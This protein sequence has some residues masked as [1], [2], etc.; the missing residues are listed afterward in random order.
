[1]VKH[2]DAKSKYRVIK[3]TIAG[4]FALLLIM[5]VTLYI[6]ENNLKNVTLNFNGHVY[7]ARTLETTIAGFMKDN[8]IPFNDNVD[9][10]SV[11]VND[12][13]EKEANTIAIKTAVPVTVKWDGNEKEVMTYY[14]TVGQLLDEMK[15]TVYEDDKLLNCSLDTSLSANMTIEIVRVTKGIKIEKTL[16]QNYIELIENQNMALNETHVLDDGQLGEKTYIYEITYENGVEVNRQ[17]SLEEVTREPVN[18]K[19]EIG[20]IPSKTDPN[21]GKTFMYLRYET[22]VATAYTLDP[23]ECGGKAPGDPGYGITA[24]GM[25]ADTGVIA[26]DKSVIP[27]GTKVYIET[28]SGAFQNYGFAVAGDTGTGIKGNRIDLFMYDKQDALDWGIRK[29][30]VYFIYEK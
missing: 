16:L 1:M 29:V 22:F 7:A 8:N 2:H 6:F 11:D 15:I 17:L 25:K 9:F 23:D 21:T 30:R 12:S 13:L 28:I 24:S 20:V 3:H 4:I 10:I 19:I 18:K 27:F 5:L 14:E 26:V